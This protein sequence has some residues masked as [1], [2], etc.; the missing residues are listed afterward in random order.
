MQKHLC[1]FPLEHVIEIMRPLPT[2]PMRGA[3]A[4]VTGVAV[5]RGSPA[6]VVDTARLLGD[7]AS[8]PTRFVAVRA[9]SRCIALAVDRVLGVHALARESMHSVPRLLHH[10]GERMIS[11]LGTMDT[12]LLLVLESTHVLPED[13][14]D[15]PARPAS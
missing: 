5:V 6:V 2:E 10:T 13:F 3:P 14:L 7:E 4:F 8:D 9:R 12:E 15:G 1:A 11:A